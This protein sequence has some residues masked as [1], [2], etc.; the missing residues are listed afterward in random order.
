MT[1]T[2]AWL[3]YM[4]VLR[5]RAPVTAA[6]LRP[7]RPLADREDAERATT[8]WTSELREFFALHDGQPDRDDHGSLLGTM[9]PD[10]RLLSIDEMVAQH[11]FSRENL[12]LAQDLRPDWPATVEAQV[13]GDEAAMFLD[14]YVPF[15]EDGAGDFRYVDT[16]RG[17][18]RGC[19]RY[20]AADGADDGG[21]IFASLADYIDSVRRS[22]ESG[23]EHSY[24]TPTL[25]DGALI[26]K[27]DYSDDPA[28]P[29]PAPTLLSLPFPLRDFQPS[30]VGDAELVDLDV[31]RRTVLTAAQSLHPGA[32]VR[33]GETVFR[34]VPRR[35]GVSMNSCVWIDEVPTF[36]LTIVTGDGNEVLVYEMPPGGFEFAVD[37]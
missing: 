10:L 17:E 9:L 26:W 32:V 5:D 33:G 28:P 30:Q 36:Y 23:A 13:A 35:R 12:H 31:I 34:Q 27:V 25:N 20:F 8:G 29:S 37:S 4:E 19:V 18:H 3:A 16:R 21:P 11:I 14:A 2:D 15:A 7:P 22:V 6:A 1:L 24:L